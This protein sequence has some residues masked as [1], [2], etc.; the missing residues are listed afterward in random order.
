MQ[1]YKPESKRRSM[2]WRHLGS[3]SVKKI[4]DLAVSWKLLLAVYCDCK[5]CILEHYPEQGQTLTS[6]QCNVLRGQ[7]DTIVQTSLIT[8][9]WQRA[10]GLHTWSLYDLGLRSLPI[11]L[12]ARTSHRLTSTNIFVSWRPRWEGE[13]EYIFLLADEHL[14][15]RW[16][17][18]LGR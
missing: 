6:A 17:K 12:T 13:V 2:Q 3:P 15:P 11:Q 9:T 18:C 8:D 16:N 10:Y 14:V 5:R 4:Q 7:A 1:H